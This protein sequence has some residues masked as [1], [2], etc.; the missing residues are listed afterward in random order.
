MCLELV[1]W[2]MELNKCNTANRPHPCLQQVENT[3]KFMIMCRRIE[4]YM[5]GVN[6]SSLQYLEIQCGLFY[7]FLLPR[8]FNNLTSCCLET[9]V[10]SICGLSVS[11]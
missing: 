7:L 10:F 3:E 8:S 5:S 9:L 1:A 6:I 11:K 4:V 2:M